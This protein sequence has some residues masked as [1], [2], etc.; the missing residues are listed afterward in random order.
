MNQY[1]SPPPAARKV[2]QPSARVGEC[3]CEQKMM[4]DIAGIMRAQPHGTLGR[5]RQFVSDASHE[6]FTPIA[7]L[8]A[9]LEEARLH[10][11]ETGL[12]TLLVGALSDVCRLQAIVADLLVLARPE[13]HAAERWELMNLGDLVQSV[14]SRRTDRC[15]VTLRVQGGVIVNAVRCDMTRLFGNLLDNAQRHAVDTVHV[16]V[17]RRGDTAEL[18]V[19]DDGVGIAGT[20]RE[21]IFEVFTRLDASRCRR[22]GGPGLGLAIARGLAWAHGG[23]L[24]V[25]DSP[26]GACFALRLPLARPDADGAAAP[27]SRA[28][29]HA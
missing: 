18:V 25:E 26:F 5:Q 13:A 9:R 8:R 15:E 4:Q 19:A 21:R 24:C 1:H 6:L 29:V 28:E 22:Y 17:R 14:L 16:E 7:G 20:D 10:P 12:E 3:G 27:G 2:A 23:T 11:G